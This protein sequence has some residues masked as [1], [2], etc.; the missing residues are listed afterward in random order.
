MYNLTAASICRPVEANGPVIGAKK[1]ILKGA[2]CAPVWPKPK[3][4]GA[5]AMA[6]IKLR[7]CIVVS[8]GGYCEKE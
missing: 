8:F 5:A 4:K 1:P 3:V 6:L 7:F 2:V